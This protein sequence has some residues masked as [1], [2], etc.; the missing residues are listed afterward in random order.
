MP[1]RD[2]DALLREKPVVRVSR[3][4]IWPPVEDTNPERLDVHA[5]TIHDYTRKHGVCRGIDRAHGPNGSE[6]TGLRRRDLNLP[7]GTLAIVASKTEA[8]VRIVDLDP[9]LRDELASYV[10]GADL[11]PDDFLFPGRGGRRRERNAVRA[12]ILYPAIDRANAF[13]EDKG[14]PTISDDVTFHSL[15]RTYASL[16]AEAN[17]DPA[18]TAA[19]IGHED[20]TLHAEGVHG[21]SSAHGKPCLEAGALVRSAAEWAPMGTSAEIVDSETRAVEAARE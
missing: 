13:L 9:W 21:R 5:F 12:K 3:R 14:L 2:I 19:Q 7:A 11:E 1:L 10:A 20:A 16:A 6:V 15:R 17:V 8:G 18:W 4:P